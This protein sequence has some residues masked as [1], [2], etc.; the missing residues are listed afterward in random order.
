[1]RLNYEYQNMKIRWKKE[2]FIP[3]GNLD[4]K[5]SM[6]AWGDKFPVCDTVPNSNIMSILNDH[7]KSGISQSWKSGFKI[8]NKNFVV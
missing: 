8:S 2:N 6:I 3:T 4:K 1:M 7:N 5:Q